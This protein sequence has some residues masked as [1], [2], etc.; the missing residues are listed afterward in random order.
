MPLRPTVDRERL[1][2]SIDD[3]ATI[4]VTPGGGV[5]RLALSEEDRVVR[6]RF[7]ADVAAAGATTTVDDVG[8]I[9]ARRPGREDLPPIQIGSHLDSVRNGGRFD[10]ALT[11]PTS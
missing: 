3:Y 11:E 1:L 2:A 8:N 9:I 6:D 10:G 7:R 5:T 4:G